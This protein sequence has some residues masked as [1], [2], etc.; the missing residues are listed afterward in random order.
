MSLP[1]RVGGWLYAKAAQHALLSGWR[2]LIVELDYERHQYHDDPDETA[3][4]LLIDAALF[5]GGA[6][7]DFLA[8]RGSLLPEDERLLAEQWLL[9]DRS[10]FEVEQ[11]RPGH[12][13]T[14]RDVRTGDIHEVLERT[15]S[16]QLTAGQLI[17]TRVLP[18]GGDT[19]QFF[20]GLEPVALHHRDALIALLDE[21]P[22]GGPRRV[23]EPPVRSADAGEH[24]GRPADDLR[25]HHPRQRFGGIA[26]RA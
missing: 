18:A 15:A 22:D 12:A 13:V 23:S 2:D 16:R 14:V 24:R 10:L 8:V 26:V 3:D 7:E 25:S 6:F 11:V 9:V 5:E 1:E 21:G 20:G 4:P 17:C 19:A